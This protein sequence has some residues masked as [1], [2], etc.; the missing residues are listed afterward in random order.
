MGSESVVLPDVCQEN[1]FDKI[2]TRDQPGKFVLLQTY[3][4]RKLYFLFM[5]SQLSL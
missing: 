5:Y 4:D 2:I 1:V 3:H